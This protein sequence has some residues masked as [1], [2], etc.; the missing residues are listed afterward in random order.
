MEF[1]RQH[2]YAQGS[3]NVRYELDDDY[4]GTWPVPSLQYTGDVFSGQSQTGNVCFMIA[5]NEAASLMFFT[6]TEYQQQ[7][8]FA[9]R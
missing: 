8:W 7:V 5:S 6:E 2:L 1:F 4:C 3:H 9:L